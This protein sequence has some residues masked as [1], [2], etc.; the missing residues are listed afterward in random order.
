MFTLISDKLKQQNELEWVW[1]RR[2]ITCHSAWGTILIM[3]KDIRKVGSATQMNILMLGPSLP[4]MM[5][6]NFANSKEERWKEWV[7]EFILKFIQGKPM[8]WLKFWLECS[9]SC[10]SCYNAFGRTFKNDLGVL[11]NKTELA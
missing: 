3:Q 11:G 6:I 5:K 9:E 10:Q 2:N 4:I 1:I 7:L 8:A